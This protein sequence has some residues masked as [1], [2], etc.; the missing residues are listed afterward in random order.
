M[1]MEVCGF[2]LLSLAL[3]PFCTTFCVHHTK[4]CARAVS[5]PYG[6]SSGSLLTTKNMKGSNGLTECGEQGLSSY[7][8]PIGS[9]SV[10]DDV[11]MTFQDDNP[12]RT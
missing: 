7:F 10:V 6:Y 8:M 11:P 5:S 4:W 1:I 2:Y 12:R 9:G 3:C